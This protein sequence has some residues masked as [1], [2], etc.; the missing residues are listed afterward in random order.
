MCWV[1]L[2][3]GKPLTLILAESALETVP[4]E[5]LDH[6]QIRKHAEKAGRKP[7]NLILDKSYHYEAMAKLRDKEKR[8]RP[9]IVHFCLLE[10]LG[11]PLNLEGLLRIYVHTYSSYVITVNPETRLP[12][13]YNRFIGL[14]EQLFQV[15]RVPPEGKPLLTLRKLSLGKLL[16][17]LKLNPVVALTRRGKP[18]TVRGL[19]DR[20]AEA[21]NPGV[22]IGGFPHGGF[23]RQTLSRV[24]EA[25]AID[26]EGLDSWIVVS[27]VLSAY[28]EALKLPEK[29]LKPA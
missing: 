22:V 24:D 28:E 13:N 7:E 2:T 23:S 17:R 25:V 8:G 19:A 1:K 10:A 29:R 6:P 21:E 11:S 20:L 26:F 27:R 3:K 16:G 18:E 4:R 9:D 14:M 5:I 15:G 12:R